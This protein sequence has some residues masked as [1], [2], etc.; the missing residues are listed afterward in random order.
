MI[1]PLHLLPTITPTINAMKYSIFWQIVVAYNLL[2]A[3]ISKWKPSQLLDEAQSYFD[4]MLLARDALHLHAHNTNTSESRGFPPNSKIQQA[5]IPPANTVTMNLMLNSVLRA[6]RADSIAKCDDIL[7][8]AMQRGVRPDDET[9]QVMLR[10]WGGAERDWERAQGR[11]AHAKGIKPYGAVSKSRKNIEDIA[12]RAQ[13]LFDRMV[14]RQ[15]AHTASTPSASQDVERHE[16]NGPDHST[17][18]SLVEVWSQRDPQRATNILHHMLSKGFKPLPSTLV[19]VLTAWARQNLV[20]ECEAVFRRMVRHG[21]RPDGSCGLV[22]IDAISAD[23]STSYARE[24][25]GK[26]ASDLL[27]FISQF[28]GEITPQ[29]VGDTQ[30]THSAHV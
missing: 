24:N 30:I 2:F 3:C 22:V 8:S 5:E 15:P 26:K 6:A 25:A 18:A 1:L 17:Y 9:F 28:G 11:A 27:D 20:A 21:L 10:V 19:C 7:H 4:A 23:D 16:M 29:M 13:A 14:A 12:E